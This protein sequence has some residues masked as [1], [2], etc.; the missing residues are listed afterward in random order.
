MAEILAR[1]FQPGKV[2]LAFAPRTPTWVKLLVE[3]RYAT[4]AAGDAGLLGE[5]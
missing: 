1:Q 4:P 5:I 3:L 2:A